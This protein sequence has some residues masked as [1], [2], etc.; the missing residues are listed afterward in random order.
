MEGYIK[1]H[2]S[3][4]G[5]RWFKDPAPSHLFVY[6]LLRANYSEA[7][8]RE[9]KIKP[10][11]LVTSRHTLSQETGLSEKVV[12]LC[13]K[14]LS[15]TGE[16]VVESKS[17]YSIITIC[18]YADY[19]RVWL[20][21]GQVK[22]NG[23]PTLGQVKA[24]NKEEK[25]IIMGGTN[26][27]SIATTDISMSHDL[28]A[29]MDFF[30]QTMREHKAQIPC[31]LKIEG[32]RR[33]ALMARLKESGVDAI[34]TVVINAASSSFLNGGSERPFV[35]NFDWIFRPNNFQKILEGNYNNKI[36]ISNFN[37]N[38]A[39]RQSMQVRIEQELANSQEYFNNL[40]IRRREKLRDG[41]H[42]KIW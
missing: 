27:P 22:A 28:Q 20:D 33:Q 21:M 13:L 9:I 8:W 5:W 30:N 15:R 11:Q 2:R 24:T 29:F 16:I 23:G 31:I 35:A 3:F 37:P 1:L 14:K 34:K 18:K 39:N 19:Q 41:V 26:V 38:G 10:G 4:L 36:L 40:E 12:R 6:M 17:N 32:N 7:D 42:K 25:K